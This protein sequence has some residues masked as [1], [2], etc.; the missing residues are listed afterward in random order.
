MF[1]QKI[2][3][4]RA[5]KGSVYSLVSPSLCYGGYRFYTSR[6]K[7]FNFEFSLKNINKKST[8]NSPQ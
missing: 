8:Y 1:K 3:N 5:P 6:N 7:T 2:D 4:G